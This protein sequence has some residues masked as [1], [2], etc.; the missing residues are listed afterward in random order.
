VLH[1][2]YKVTI[3]VPREVHWEVGVGE[4]GDVTAHVHSAY[5]CSEHTVLQ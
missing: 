3:H 4:G 5:S 1:V 2:L